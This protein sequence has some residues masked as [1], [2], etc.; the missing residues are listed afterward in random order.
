MVCAGKH[1]TSYEH[2]KYYFQCHWPVF[3]SMIAVNHFQSFRMLIQD[4]VGKC[5]LHVSSGEISEKSIQ[6]EQD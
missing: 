4:V 5:Y 6:G 3:A 2:W 1:F